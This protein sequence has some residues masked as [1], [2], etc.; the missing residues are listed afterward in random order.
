MSFKGQLGNFQPEGDKTLDDYIYQKDLCRYFFDI[1]KVRDDM[2][3][4]REEVENN[5]YKDEITRG[6]LGGIS[7]MATLLL[8]LWRFRR[9]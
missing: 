2:Q 6:S 3:K 9:R 8:I 7:V 4:N 1:R 5:T